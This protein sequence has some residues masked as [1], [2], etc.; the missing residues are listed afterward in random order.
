MNKLKKLKIVLV[1]HKN[2]ELTPPYDSVF[3]IFWYCI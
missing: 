2:K 1:V 3:S